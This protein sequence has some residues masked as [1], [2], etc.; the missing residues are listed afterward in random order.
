MSTCTKLLRRDPSRPDDITECGRTA[1]YQQRYE[2]VAGWA[3]EGFRC[4]EH[5]I[6]A[7]ARDHLRTVAVSA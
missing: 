3:V 5:R 4:D 7:D 1:T 2:S 6:P